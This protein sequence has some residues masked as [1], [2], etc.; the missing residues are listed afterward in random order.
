MCNTPNIFL[1]D[2]PN[3]RRGLDLPIHRCYFSGLF[4]TI[5]QVTRRAKRTER[6]TKCTGRPVLPV[7]L[8]IIIHN[9][10]KFPVHLHLFI[11]KWF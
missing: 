3:V 8:L 4:V 5:S 6:E 2:V 1:V 10:T 7:A 9:S 11:Y